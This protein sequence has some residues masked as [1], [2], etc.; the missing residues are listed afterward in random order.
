M[1]AYKLPTIFGHRSLGE[2]IIRYLHPGHC[3]GVAVL[4]VKKLFEVLVDER[5]NSLACTELIT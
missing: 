2:A 5:L 3:Q 4:Y 1:F